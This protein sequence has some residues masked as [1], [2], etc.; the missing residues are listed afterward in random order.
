MAE[1]TYAMY[2]CSAFIVITLPEQ[3]GIFCVTE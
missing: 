2:L 3:C 1:K